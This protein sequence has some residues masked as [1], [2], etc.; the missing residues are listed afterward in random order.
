MLARGEVGSG[1]GNGARGEGGSDRRERKT[2]KRK[3]GRRSAGGAHS[4]RRLALGRQRP[5]E[6]P[7]ML[8]ISGER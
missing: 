2:G 4:K 6:A 1:G 5:S 7:P 3:G 8:G